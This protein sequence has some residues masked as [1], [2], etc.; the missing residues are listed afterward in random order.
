MRLVLPTSIRRSVEFGLTLSGLL[1][2]QVVAT[3]QPL[4]F[5][6]ITAD[7]LQTKTHQTIPLLERCLTKNIAQF[8]LENGLDHQ[9]GGYRDHAMTANP[10]DR[11]IKGLVTQTRLLCFFSR[12]SR[13][14]YRQASHLEADHHGYQFL[15]QYF[16]DNQEGGFVW[17][18]DRSGAQILRSDKHLY[19]QAFALYTLSE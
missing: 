5:P 17:A 16:W 3:L 13:S 1:K 19:G 7:A 11:C 9:Y 4:G 2:D 12:L 10:N 15:I 14:T 6:S 8:W 18:V